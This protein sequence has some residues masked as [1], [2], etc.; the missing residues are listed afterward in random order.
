MIGDSRE[1][2][3]AGAREIS[4]QDFSGEVENLNN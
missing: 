2:E 4:E 1:Q 3:E